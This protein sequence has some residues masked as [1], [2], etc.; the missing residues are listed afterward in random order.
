MVSPLWFCSK[1]CLSS[2]SERFWGDR[3]SCFWSLREGLAHGLGD[4]VGVVGSGMVI[5]VEMGRGLQPPGLGRESWRSPH[6]VY[7]LALLQVVGSR[8]L[9]ADQQLWPG[10]ALVL[11]NLCLLPAERCLWAQAALLLHV[12]ISPCASHFVSSRRGAQLCQ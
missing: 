5:C 6:P 4:V 2:V 9:L 7:G 3:V 8:S 11:G 12:Q 1:L 10:F